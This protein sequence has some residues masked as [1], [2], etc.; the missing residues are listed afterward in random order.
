MITSL[1]VDRNV[2]SYLPVYEFVQFRKTCHTLYD[3]DEAWAVRAKK[4]SPIVT[5]P[6]HQIG[7]H[8]LLTWASKLPSHTG[9][10]EWYQ[11][12]VDWLQYKISIK[13]IHD[14]IRSKNVLFLHTMTMQN[15]TPSQRYQW[16]YM[17][18]RYSRL[19][20]PMLDEHDGARRKR[21]KIGIPCQRFIQPCYG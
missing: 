14:F 6:K 19:Y 21:F 8:Y 4:V 12:L 13:I 11:E 18:H 3:D 1:C 15:M 10:H 17:W 2:S 20:K 7:L 16:K 9:T 5:N